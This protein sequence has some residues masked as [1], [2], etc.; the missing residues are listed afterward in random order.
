MPTPP[1]GGMAAQLWRYRRYILGGALVEL[2]QRYAGSAI[3]ILW[4]VVTP[5]V[6]ILIY[7][8]VFSQLLRER[9]GARTET[10]YAVFLCAGLLPWLVFAECL[11]R[12]SNIL[13]ISENYLRKLAIP[14]VVFVAQSVAT[15]AM[16][17]GIYS[18]A[19]LIMAWVSGIQPTA[20]W[21]VLPLVMLLFLGLCFG[22]ALILSTVSVFFRDLVQVTSI[23][24]QV[25]FWITPIVYDMSV[26][27]PGLKRVV[28][29]NPPS[30]YITSTREILLR[31]TGPALD[32]WA[33]MLGFCAAFLFLGT[34]I[35][36]RLRTDLRDAL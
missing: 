34:L 6:Q 36:G 25:W 27:R 13:L 4:H 35:L 24:T 12:G 3:G 11:T 7:G 19:L 5:L 15:S 22:V 16:T 30:A 8:I 21:L 31:G 10:H 33:W 17:L 9:G 2:R 26:L 32:E 23:A 14:E 1:R 20:A 18:I 28:A 29:L